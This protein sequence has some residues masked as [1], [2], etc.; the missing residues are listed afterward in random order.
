MMMKQKIK[1]GLYVS[2]LFL[3]FSAQAQAQTI[4]LEN[5]MAFTS[6][7]GN[8]GISV[9]V[10]RPYQI[11]LGV[12]YLDREWFNLSSQVGYIRKGGKDKIPVSNGDQSAPTDHV[13]MKMGADYVS[14]NTTFQLKRNVRNETYYVGAGPRVDFKVNNVSSF[15][16][17]DDVLKSKQV[18]YG[19]KCEAGFDYTIRKLLLG[20]NF[21][22]LPTFNKQVDPGYEI[23]FRDQSFTLGFV[24]GYLL[25]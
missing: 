4:K 2:I 23:T 14:A 12:S 19:L 20:V 9:G 17:I 11:A 10:M 21:S 6:L 24:V 7:K 22:Y 1:A 8:E 15:V 16:G 18:L 3:Y 25:K 5:G 13:Y